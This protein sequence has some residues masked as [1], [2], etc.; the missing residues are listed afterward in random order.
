MA[1]LSSENFVSKEETQATY[2]QFL[3][4]WH[5]ASSRADNLTASWRG[6]IDVSAS[7]KVL[8][9]ENVYVINVHRR[10]SARERSGALSGICAAAL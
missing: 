7:M 5:R 6:V 1:W 10:L 2:R 3:A 4:Q 8:E 9:Y